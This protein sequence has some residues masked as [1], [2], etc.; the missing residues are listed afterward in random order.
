[1]RAGARLL[2]LPALRDDYALLRHDD[3]GA[4]PLLHCFDPSEVRDD[5][6]SRNLDDPMLAVIVHGD[7]VED[8]AQH[9]FAGRILSR[10]DL[11]SLRGGEPLS[12]SRP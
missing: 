2:Q 11:S 3:P 6:A 9:P 12:Q 8:L 7:A 10:L 1:M 5:D 4:S